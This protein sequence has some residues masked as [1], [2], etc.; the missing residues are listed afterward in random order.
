MLVKKA[1]L[2]KAIYPGG[3]SKHCSACKKKATHCSMALNIF[4]CFAPFLVYTSGA[5]K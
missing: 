4:C 3:L 2:G 1:T 5:I